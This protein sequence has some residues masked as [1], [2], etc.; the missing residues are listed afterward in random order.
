[1][2]CTVLAAPFPRVRVG[3]V[4]TLHVYPLTIKY[5]SLAKNMIF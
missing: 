3:I 5:A 2:Y 1:M 4:S